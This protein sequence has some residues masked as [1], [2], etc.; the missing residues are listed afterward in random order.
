MQ[1]VKEYRYHIE[2][3][4]VL[5]GYHI[6]NFNDGSKKFYGWTLETLLGIEKNKKSDDYHDYP[7]SFAN[8]LQAIRDQFPEDFI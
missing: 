4:E 7:Y 8:I 2:G 6:I 1:I 5:Y 3:T